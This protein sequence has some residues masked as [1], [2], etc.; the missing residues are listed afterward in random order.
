MKTSEQLSS[1]RSRD[2]GLGGV[3]APS[4]RDPEGIR[5]YLN[6]LSGG[7]V[8]DV[9][10]SGPVFGALPSRRPGTRRALVPALTRRSHRVLLGLTFAFVVTLTA[11]FVWWVSPVHRLS[12]PGFVANSVLLA[13]VLAS[14]LYFLYIVNQ[15]RRVNPNVPVPDVRVAMVVTKAPSEPWPMVQATLEAM[16]AQDYPGDFDVW[17]ADEDPADETIDWCYSRGVRIST[18]QGAKGYQR[19]TWPRRRRCKEGNLAYFYDHYGYAAY[20]VVSQLD[21]D[22]VPDRHYLREMVRPFWDDA[23]GYVA[24]PSMCDAN[25]EQ[26]WAVMGRPYEEAF[27]HGALQLGLSADGTPVCIGSHYAVR[28]AALR[29]IGGVGPELAEDFTTSYLLNVA[30]WR[31]EYAIDAAARGDP[32]VPVVAKPHQGPDEPRAPHLDQVARR[33]WPAVHLPVRLQRPAEPDVRRRSRPLLHGERNRVAVGVGQHPRLLRAVGRHERVAPPHRGSPASQRTQQA[34]RLSH[35]ELAA[36]PVCGESPAALVESVVPRSIDFKVTPKGD[37]GPQP[38]PVRLVLPFAAVAVILA[39]SAW[40]GLDSPDVIGY[41]GLSL[42]TALS[43]V[44]VATAVT[45]LHAVETRR[46]TGIG[47]PQAMRLV[48]APLI[49][50]V[51]VGAAVS[52]V[53]Y[54]YAIE[55]W[56]FLAA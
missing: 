7:C 8:V 2:E 55:L 38:F 1:V 22:H 10:A 11:F 40:M 32:G 51:L 17:L 6:E 53:S 54:L 52:T 39:G 43:Q 30:G 27:F 37:V 19:L 47:R 21:A 44:V 46:N 3:P 5:Q 4:R 35:R 18:R 56:R 41:V 23:V 14:P 12:W 49:V 9:R 16:L 26:S 29:Q 33:P 20:D 25:G 24:A 13:I 45:V 48:G 28:T 34:G 42:L 50:C 15:M 36:R 31:G